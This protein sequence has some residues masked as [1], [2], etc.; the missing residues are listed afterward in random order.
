[1]PALENPGEHRL[2]VCRGECSRELTRACPVELV[3]GST[4]ALTIPGLSLSR[5]RGPTW[6][7][8]LLSRKRDWKEGGA[9]SAQS[10]LERFFLQRCCCWVFAV[11]AP[12]LSSVPFLCRGQS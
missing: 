12:R 5:Q 4:S 2:G 3:E 8:G 10:I 6:L 11:E 7:R 1:M 9:D